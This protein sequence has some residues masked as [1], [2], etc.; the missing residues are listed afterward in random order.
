MAV[1][2]ENEWNFWRENGYVVIPNAVPQE[3]LDRTVEAISKI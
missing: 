1:L 2:T 3:Q